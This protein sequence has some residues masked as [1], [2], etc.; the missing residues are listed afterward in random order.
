MTPGRQGGATAAG[1]ESAPAREARDRGDELLCARARGDAPDGGPRA[2]CPDH[3]PYDRD[4]DLLAPFAPGEAP[5]ARLYRPLAPAIV[6]GRA[7]RPERELHVEACLADAIPL[8]RRRGGGCAVLLDPGCL[9]LSLALPLPGLGGIHEAYD[10]I[11]SWLIEGLADLGIWGVRR[12]DA[13][14]L[15]LGDRKIGGA[16][17]YRRSGLLHY[18]AALLEQP[19]VDRMERYLQHPPREPRYRRG[20]THREFVGRLGPLGPLERIREALA[21]A[22]LFRTGR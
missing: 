12:R 14:D 20:R 8:Y 15:A 7:S 3:L 10:R 17:I 19:R 4:D 21:P 1:A 13:C 11:T 22:T 5:R 18:A 16:C 6:L 2:A 9:V